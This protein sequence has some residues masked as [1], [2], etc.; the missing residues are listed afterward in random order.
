[1][2]QSLGKRIVANRKRLGLTQDQLAEQLGVTAQAVSKWENDQ[3][4]PDITMLPRLA[5]IFGVSADQLLGMEP[6]AEAPVHQAEVVSDSGDDESGSGG[7]WHFSY[8]GAR[9][10]SI[11]FALWILLSGGLLLAS[12]LLG[13]DVGFWEILWP[14]GLLVF[15]L[16]GL[17]F[18]FSFFKL[19]CGLLGGYF[20][21]R[22]LGFLP[23]FGKELLLPAFLLLFGLSL[24][25]DAFRKPKHPGFRVIHNG[26]RVCE[27]EK[28][29]TTHLDQEGTGFSCSTSFGEDRHI[30]DVARLTHGSASVSFGSL[31]VDLSGCGEIVPNCSIQAEC[32][33]GEL[34][35][36]IPRHC[37]VEPSAD[38]S[39]GSMDIQGSPAP[40]A[41]VP[42][43]LDC[44]ASFG[45]ITVRYI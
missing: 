29:H 5:A 11:A 34:T 8:N 25:V 12:G 14:C 36:L 1:M 15:G 6:P 16:L 27:G 31:T 33:F 26:R 30:I 9:K 39:F 41:T 45:S 42:V 40:D 43:L 3:S 20:L 19:G 23:L 24:L 22:N 37:R 28:K 10:G 17:C 2:D 13:W 21:L 18:R 44:D 35:L 7:S 4:C 38:T 32:A